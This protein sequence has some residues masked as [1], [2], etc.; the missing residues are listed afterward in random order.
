MDSITHAQTVLDATVRLVEAH[1]YQIVNNEGEPVDVYIQETEEEDDVERP[2]FSEIDEPLSM[3]V[4]R[5]AYDIFAELMSSFVNHAPNA[6]TM[7]LIVSMWYALP[8]TFGCH[9]KCDPEINKDVMHTR[10]I[11]AIIGWCA[12]RQSA[13]WTLTIYT[14]LNRERA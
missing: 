12:P 11:R 2:E 1:G 9:V 8:E 4:W 7:A 13:W 14:A 6:E 3:D 10:D 5:K